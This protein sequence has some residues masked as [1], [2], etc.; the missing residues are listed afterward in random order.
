M[1]W[2]GQAYKAPLLE[3]DRVR[4]IIE[5]F[6]ISEE[7]A[8]KIPPTN[9]DNTTLILAVETVAERMRLGAEF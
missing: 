7:M 2:D 4:V 8:A 5:E 3:A 1:G 9:P 6:G